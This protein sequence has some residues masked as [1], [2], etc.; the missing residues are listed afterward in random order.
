[1][2][3][4]RKALFLF[5]VAIVSF[6]AMRVFYRKQ[7]SEAEKERR[8]LSSYKKLIEE[9]SETVIPATD[10]PGAKDARVTDYII[11]VVEN[12]LSEKDRIVIL[13][14]LE[15]LEKYCIKRFSTSFTICTPE[16]KVA[17]LQYFEKKWILPNPFLNK[18]RRKIV[19]QTFFEQMKL[20]IVSGYCTSELGA[21]KGLAYDHIPRKY[22]PCVPY[23]PHQRSWA[24]S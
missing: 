18:V 13:S 10:S 9:I 5:V 21:T 20:L 1:M 24:T 19:G 23:M 15:D 22:V 8:A 14:G 11:N 12:C 4:R 2:I 17:V 7:I 3:T 16:N 6:V